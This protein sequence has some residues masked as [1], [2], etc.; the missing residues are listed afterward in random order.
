[1][2]ENRLRE[3]ERTLLGV[4]SAT[5][6][7]QLPTILSQ[8]FQIHHAS[9]ITTLENSPLPAQTYKPTVIQGRAA[10]EYWAKFTL[11]T[12]ADVIRWH[13]DQV[14][15]NT[16]HCHGVMDANRGGD[17]LGNLENNSE[18]P[19]LQEGHL[20]ERT[21]QHDFAALDQYQHHIGHTEECQLDSPG[22]P[23]QYAT[24]QQVESDHQN[25][26]QAVDSAQFQ[27]LLTADTG[28]HGLGIPL[29]F[30]QTFL[31]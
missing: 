30:Q 2:L 1:M 21:I 25:G 23:C 15:S 20:T 17:P 11:G 4:L 7:E 26:R 24:D 29:K 12:P 16:G 18:A 9:E 22:P 31:W 3:T 8:C 6:V 14:A 10:A 28:A 19:I 13:Q 5:P 27:R